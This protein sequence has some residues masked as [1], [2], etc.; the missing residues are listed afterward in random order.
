MASLPGA[1]LY[2]LLGVGS[3][4]ENVAPAVPAD[5]FVALGGLL[6]TLGMASPLGVFLATWTCNV[7][8][9][10]AMYGLAHRHGRGLVGTRVGRLVLRPHQL[11]RMERFYGRFGL[12]AI[13]FTRFLPGLRAVVPVF[14]GITHQRFWAVAIPVAVASAIWH[15]ALVGLGMVAG[16]NLD[17]LERLLG[18][19]Q[20]VLGL[21]AGLL[22]LL[23]AIWWWRSRHPPRD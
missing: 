9:A 21:L 6:S 14:A 18:R 16:R 23:V 12:P 3:A 5:T 2:V 22:I 19:V 15:A 7:G 20:G 4:L 1:T 10:L 8:S 13:F 11:E 17:L